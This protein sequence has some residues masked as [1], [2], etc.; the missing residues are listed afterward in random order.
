MIDRLI[1]MA[2]AVFLGLSACDVVR[3]EVYSPGGY[4]AVQA[5]RYQ[6]A[7]TPAQHV[8]RY[9][10]FFF[11]AAPLALTA[12]YDAESAQDAAEDVA[13][14]WEAL[15]DL[16]DA[17][18]KCGLHEGTLPRLCSDAQERETPLDASGHSI[19][20]TTAEEV[21]DS[22]LSFET[23]SLEVQRELGD[24]S[25][26]MAEN[27]GVRFDIDS[28]DLSTIS[29]VLGTILDMRSQAPALREAAATYRDMTHIFVRSVA[30][31]CTAYPN[32][33]TRTTSVAAAKR[34]CG[35]LNAELKDFYDDGANWVQPS[36][37][38]NASGERRLKRLLNQ[39]RDV[40]E[41]RRASGDGS[42]RYWSIGAPS[43]SAYILSR[44]QQSGT[45][46][47]VND[48]LVKACGELN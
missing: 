43:A 5:D 21:A 13:E 9:R 45:R 8:D 29:S 14:A 35:D 38:D 27:I 16:S 25:Y 44:C 42:W 17:V 10:T 26:R 3:D 1:F 22:M 12:A 36:L 40:I 20:V 39:S 30:A 18:E 31:S 2:P 33:G 47:G 37:E 19:P 46:F 6:K 41:A 28:F 24:L 23:L 34:H 4:V 7:V 15:E 11:F 48:K 32:N